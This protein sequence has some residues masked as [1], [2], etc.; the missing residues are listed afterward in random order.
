MEAKECQKSVL[1]VARLSAFGLRIS[2]VFRPSD[3]GFRVS[4]VLLA[5]FIMLALDSLAQSPPPAS[6][7]D[8]LMQLMLA[9][10]RIEIDVPVLPTVAFDP[11]VVKPGEESTYRVTFNALETAIEWPDKIPAPQ[12]LAP[13]AGAHAQILSLS[14]PMLVPRTTFN[15][16]VKPS[17]A[18]KYT[19]P[20]FTVMV[21]G[22]PVT[23]P[24]AEIEAV[25]D[26]PP[27]IP[28][29]Q[30]LLLDLPTNDVFVGQT[31]H[32]R[33]LLPGSASGV[34][35]SL[36]QVQMNGQGFIVDQT[37]AHARIEAM[38]LGPY[39]HP[40]NTFVHELMLTPIA[41]GKL[42]I[43]AQGFAV[44]NRIVGGVIMPGP[45]ASQQFTLVD[46]DPV[47]FEVRPLPHGTELPGFTG[48]VGGYSVEFP[49]LSTN[50]LTVGEPVRLRVKVHGDGNLARLV[51]PSPPQLRDWQIFPAP[52][53]NTP[54][55]IIRAQGAVTFT[56]TLI[57]MRE[58]IRATPAVPFC[59]FDPERKVFQD[60][61][62]VSVPV[63]VLPGTAT[64]A[65]LQ[66]IVQAESIDKS[67]E[68]EPVLS[69]LSAALGLKG[70]LAPAQQSSWFP[71]LHLLPAI[72][73]L[74]LWLWDRRRRFLEQH[75]DIVLRRR[76]LRALRRE[77]RALERAASNRD[78][79]RFA[80]VAVNAMK[81]AV[82]P[83]YPAEPR[84][85]V[86]ADVLTILPESERTG[87]IG[88][89]VRRLFSRED[90]FCFAAKPGDTTGILEL[91]PEIEGVLDH[92]QAR[93]CN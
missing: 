4:S 74:G 8:P 16:R 93:L 22:K 56:Y 39:R 50:V 38:P 12:K 53:E 3:F 49:E 68:Q 77:R 27:G 45:G 29:A 40:V 51:P 66:A 42:E 43:S 75:P 90:E 23:I 21:N 13:R 52:V 34:V 46:S 78:N 5:S 20:E 91:K 73:L 11:P 76:A 35:Q 88:Q 7:P 81:V 26:V 2:A 19:M 89:T 79:A 67:Q 86:G 37:S 64:A 65:D 10:P 62:I 18:G 70:G 63:T 25:A 41:T 47:T 15:Y 55:Q 60:L 69:G 83:H 31:V 33:I 24:T 72:S 6:S 59:A 14:G 92:L 71:L 57:P 85:L 61:T 36:G 48:A 58:Q 32:A 44:G 30:Q 9:Q 54:A 1:S 82:A 84:A 80:A 28:P 87:R 17:E